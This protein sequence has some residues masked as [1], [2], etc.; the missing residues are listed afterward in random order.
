MV[1]IIHI[2]FNTMSLLIHNEISSADYSDKCYLS[3]E[4][5]EKSARVVTR[6]NHLKS[7]S[8]GK[9]C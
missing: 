4:R 5:P 6:T 3:V 8:Y 1:R 9:K 2:A 7:K